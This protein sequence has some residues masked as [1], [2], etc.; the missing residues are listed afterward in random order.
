MPRLRPQPSLRDIR[1]P[2]ERAISTASFDLPG[3]D[4]ER[5]IDRNPVTAAGSSAKSTASSNI[6][7]KVKAEAWQPFD[8]ATSTAAK[9]KAMS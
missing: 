4:C 1:G 2:V 7:A 5:N 6:E 9:V 3:V 8:H